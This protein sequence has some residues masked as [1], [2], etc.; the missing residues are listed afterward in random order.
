M[1]TKHTLAA[2]AFA[3]FTTG[4][5]QAAG[6]DY[7]AY[8]TRL[9]GSFAP[10]AFSLD[11]DGSLK[12]KST[13]AF[14]VAG[15]PNQAKVSVVFQQTGGAALGTLGDL[16][17]LSFDYNIQTST[18]IRPAVRLKLSPVAGWTEANQID[19]V[20]EPV[21]NTAT[22]PAVG[23]GSWQ[24]DVAVVGGRFWQR[25]NGSNKDA[26]ANFQTLPVWA[27]GFTPSGPNTPAGGLTFDANTP[28]YGVEVSFGSGLP[29]GFEA[30]ID[31]IRVGFGGATPVSYS[32]NVAVPEPTSLGLLGLGG[33]ALL[34]R[35]R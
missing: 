23:V 8:D 16:N 26:N 3:L 4:A 14:N 11:G 20:W 27:S 32:A 19:L 34:R 22:V 13:T 24:D 28:V 7:S 33:V 10:A 29:E 18:T 21:Y 15:S 35:R 31:D 17:A 9:G 12:L 25:S 2:L 6:L 30:Y 1:H 5:A